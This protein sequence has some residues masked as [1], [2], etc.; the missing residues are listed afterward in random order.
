[1]LRFASDTGPTSRD[2]AARQID[3]GAGG[4]MLASH[5]PADVVVERYPKAGTSTASELEMARP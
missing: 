1:M 2:V 5:H 3:A 4:A